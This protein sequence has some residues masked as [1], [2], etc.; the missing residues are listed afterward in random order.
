MCSSPVPQSRACC[1]FGSSS[2]QAV[3]STVPGGRPCFRSKRFGHAA[4]DVPPPA[5]HLAPRADQFDAALLERA[6][7]VGNQPLG[8]E[9]VD[10][11][12][13]ARTPGTSPADC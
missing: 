8:I 4:I 5:A 1:S 12:Q 3:S 2:S 13:P 9:R 6:A 11:P 10:L 7:R